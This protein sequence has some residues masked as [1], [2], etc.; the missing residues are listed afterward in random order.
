MELRE[1]PL[2]F[3]ALIGT[4]VVDKDGRRR[5][6]VFELRAH[7]DGEGAIVIDDLVVGGRALLERLRGPSAA[8]AD[9]PWEKVV[10]LG[11]DRIL[12]DDS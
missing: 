2:S 3:S 4:P 7:R 11:E 10:E 6:R 5:G 12:I 9:I 8:G 1:R